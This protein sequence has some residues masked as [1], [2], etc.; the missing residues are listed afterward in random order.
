MAQ[1]AKRRCL[2]RTPRNILLIGL[3]GSGK[4]TIGPEI[5][6]RLGRQFIDLDPV[7]L[8]RLGAASVAEAW[9]EHGEAAFRAAEAAALR[10]ALENPERV[11]AAGGGTPTAPGAA[12]LIQERRDGGLTFVV[13]LREMPGILRERLAEAGGVAD[14]PSL[15]GGDPLDEIEEVYTQRDALYRSLASQVVEGAASAEGA[16]DLIVAAVSA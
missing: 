14:R 6:A 9:R 8:W 7:T 4:S 3:R 10:D 15:T 5:A 1:P 11:I 16:V 12:E 2:S 13:Y